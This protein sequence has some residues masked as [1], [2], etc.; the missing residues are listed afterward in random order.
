MTFHDHFSAHAEGYAAHRPA[1]PQALVD[2]LAW[3]APR[4]DLAW[5]AGCGSGQLSV[6]LAERFD[7]V[8]ATD[9]SAE[10]LARATPHP[11]IDYVQA[12]AEA[13]GLP[14]ASADLAVAAQAAHWFDIDTYFA[15]VR[16]VVAPGGVVALISYGP[17]RISPELDPIFEVFRV[18]TLAAHWPPQRRH[19]EDGYRSFPFPFDE[20]PAAELP[21]LEIRLEWT[22]DELLAYVRTWSALRG[23]E[24]SRA[25]E[26]VEDLRR[27]MA[28]AWGSGGERRAGDPGAATR[29]V[30]WP[31][32]L[33]AGHV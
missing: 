30:A 10:Q 6:A 17:T 24:V 14:D 7:R 29:S 19:V 21:E 12:R 8:I 22:L 18:D 25:T 31:L 2:W 3:L 13:S 28:P 4:S 33:R 32:A 1:Y 15:E 5:E 23:M 20:V 16:R 9:A 26:L 27:R 11:R